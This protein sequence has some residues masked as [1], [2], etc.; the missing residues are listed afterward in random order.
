[1]KVF[2]KY[3][4]ITHFCD[5]KMRFTR[6]LFIFPYNSENN[7]STT[8]SWRKDRLDN[9]RG[10]RN[11][12]EIYLLY[13]G[14]SGTPLYIWQGKKGKGLWR[15]KGERV[16]EKCI[17]Y[18]WNEQIFWAFPWIFQL[19]ITSFLVPVLASDIFRLKS[20][21][22]CIWHV[23][24][25]INVVVEYFKYSSIESKKVTCYIKMLFFEILFSI[26][27]LI[28]LLNLIVLLLIV[29]VPRS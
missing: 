10:I 25:G 17:K 18:D 23:C 7:S 26:L 9:G 19:F 15:K 8:F 1:M 4:S 11:W 28:F 27:L 2:V 20:V 16:H 22:F 5:E 6:S 13:R 3:S 24:F 29:C 14:W 12:K 21:I